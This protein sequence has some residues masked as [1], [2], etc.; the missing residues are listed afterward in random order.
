MI[1]YLTL[2]NFEHYMIFKNGSIYNPNTQKF[3]KHSPNKNGY[4][5]VHLN[6]GRQLRK[7]ITIHRLIAK[8]F[9]HNPNPEKYNIVNHIDGNRHNNNP[10]NLE[11]TDQKGNM[12]HAKARGK[13]DS[14]C[15]GE[16]KLCENDVFNIRGLYFSG[17][18]IS[19]LS[20]QY[21]VHPNTI[22]KII[23]YQSWKEL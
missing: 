10:N 3:L 17:E 9:V 16:N 18:N 13:F 1:K 19:F 7:K 12:L 14:G 11:W 5:Y 8:A 20:L 21:K 4:I 2:E 15:R 22:R 23:K 6:N